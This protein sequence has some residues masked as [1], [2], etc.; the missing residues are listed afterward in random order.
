MRV[1]KIL[2]PIVLA[3]VTMGHVRAQSGNGYYRFPT[4]HGKT[5]VFTAEGDL[6]KVPVKGGIARRMTS[7]LE[8]ESHANFSPD[9]KTIAFSASYEGPAEIY[10]MLA[11]GGRPTRLTWEGYSASRKPFPV[12]WK[13]NTELLYA[14]RYFARRD[15][16]QVAVVDTKKL[17]HSV[18]PLEQASDG[19]FNESGEVFYFTRLP[20]QSSHAKRYRGGYIEN[21]WK[22]ELG[23]D[24][25][26][27]LTADFDG[28]SRDPM[29]WKDR[30][31]FATDRD[32]S[33]NLWSMNFEGQDLKQHTKF[34]G[35]DVLSPNMHKGRIV[36][37]RGA[38]IW[39][40][41][42]E[43]ASARIID[44]QLATDFDQKRVRWL[45]EPLDHLSS[46]NI[47]AD[48]T[49]ISL[50]VRGRGFV[51]PVKPGRVV[52]LPQ[53]PG[54]RFRSVAFLP[55]SDEVYY[56]SDESGETEFWSAAANGVVGKARR[57]TS[58]ATVLRYGGLAS[59]NGE[60]VAYTDR[61]QIL[62]LLDVKSGDSRRIVQSQE[63]SA[64]DSPDLAWSADSRWLAFADN[65]EN[66]IV[67]IYLLDTHAESGEPLAVTTNRLDS[68]SPG[69]SA[70]GKWLYF[71]SDRTFRTVQRSPWGPRAPE[72][73]LDKTTSIFALDLLGGQRS[74]FLADDELSKEVNKEQKDVEGD[75]AKDDATEAEDDDDEKADDK[76]AVEYDLGK[77]A[78]R[79]HRVPVDAGNYGSLRVA[80]S[81]LY[82][83]QSPIGFNSD[84]RLN[85]FPI[86]NDRDAQK[87]TQIAGDIGSYRISAD[88]SSIA[89]LNNSRPYVFS[90]N[91]KK[92]NLDDSRV[93]VSAIE[94]GVRPV[95][96]WRQIFVDAWRLHRDY[97]YDPAMHEV[98][99][100]GV[101]QRHEALL[102]R[103]STR[104]EL[105]DLIAMM[106]GE[107]SAMHTNI[108]GGDVR[109][110]DEG[111]SFGYLGATL[112]RDEA[113]GGY[114]VLHIYAN[115]PDYP[116][117]LAPLDQ[118]GVD[119]NA[120]DVITSIDGVPTLSVA[121]AKQLLQ[122]KAGRQV[123]I[124]RKR[125]G[126]AE[127]KSFIV[128]PLGQSDFRSL[129]LSEWE[130]TRRLETEKSSDG[131]IGYFHMRAMGSGNFAEFVKGFYPVFNRQGLIIDMRQNYGGNIDSWILGR[132]MRKAWM[133]WQ[134]RTGQ[135]YP[136]MQF[137]FNGHMAVLIDPYTI[138]DGEA[139]SEGFR[140][141][142]LGP[143]IGT[144][145][146]G[147]GIW[148]RSS[149]GLM[150]GGLARSPEFGVFSPDRT[151][152]IEGSGV[153][154]DIEV[155]N[156][157]HASFNGEDAQLE[158][159]IEYLQKK[160]AEDP[161]ELPQ[162]PK[163]PNKSGSED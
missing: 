159:A 157:P 119:I 27:P 88:R 108:R 76:P 91:G 26:T 32:G 30:L 122:T 107:L 106:V 41:D 141:L 63:G 133:Y 54:T 52:R 51:A 152:I 120:G 134:A 61:D 115:D 17:T 68:Y 75:K 73:Y 111:A 151:W 87:I 34:T 126:E 64:F 102:P 72:A 59:P 79:L 71:L 4:I 138:S 11:S 47:S 70:D 58:D 8:V 77:L 153:S 5:V 66:A 144:K 48:G 43:D 60:Q 84:R 163:Y 110:D 22:Y 118:A 96:E 116:G 143:L 131:K 162:A 145:T 154:P 109:E 56:L 123:L 13:S 81:H 55:E 137:A 14:T 53:K 10:T 89:L 18:L 57:I 74:P 113:A 136:N 129:K 99:W 38:D 3:L 25:A 147:G 2:L 92:P 93:E 85:A 1:C 161:R 31:Y 149:N 45:E 21:L 150:D 50:T 156:L 44:I 33:M 37:Q 29:V 125:D 35:F 86:S 139:F 155:D 114:R 104:A 65:D 7:H 124:R 158:A 103:V 46:Y 98:D 140:R 100:K 95:D 97:F 23:A 6:W 160:I 36:F 24:E 9:G 83:T 20:R 142:G 49:K 62:W 148:L 112:A 40:Y 82:F 146:W 117:D 42:I 128:R 16:Y 135:P 69:F 130:Y 105:D 15:P 101:R 67:R 19:V 127:A 90:A 39:L 12:S 132:L 80:K 28:T 121:D 94:I 78:G